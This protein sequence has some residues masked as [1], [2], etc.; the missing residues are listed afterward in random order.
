MAILLG[1]DTGGTYTDAVLFDDDISPGSTASGGV[2][3][4]AKALTTKH[5]LAE[6]IRNAIDAVLPAAPPDIRL[7]SL[8]TTLATNAIVEGHGTPV[9]LLL[10]GY[11]RDA[12][13]LAGLR[14]AVGNDPV[15]FIDGG[16]TVS[17]E[18]QMPLDVEA[19]RQAILAHAPK[20]TAFAVSGYFAVRN[21]E[22]ELAV[23]DMA[24]A[25]TGLPVSCGHE[26]TSALDAP[27]RALTTVINARLIPLLQQLILAVRGILEEKGVRASLMVVKGD[28]SLIDAEVALRQP[29]QTILS[30]P[31]ASVVGARFL[32]GEDDVLVVDMGGT[33]SDVA[34][35]QGGRPVLNR[36]GATVGGWRTMVEAVAVHTFGLGGDSEV[37]LNEAEQLVVGPRRVVP[38]SLL[39]QQRPHVLDVLRRQLA[40]QDA[41]RGVDAR[42]AVGQF[43]LRQRSLEAGRGT[44]TREQQLVWD[45]LGDGIVSLAELFAEPRAAYFRRL[46]LSQLVDRSLVVISAFT[47]TD[48]AHVLGYQSD[49]SAEA[50]SLGAALWARR[51]HGVWGESQGQEGPEDATA[52]S[53]RVMRQVVVQSGR[54]LVAA[55]LAEAHGVEL[56]DG[57]GTQHNAIRHLFVDRALDGLAHEDAVLDVTLALRRPIVAI[58]APVATYY[59][60]VAQRLHTRLCIPPYAGNANAVGAVAGGVMQTVRA[61]IKLLDAEQGY[62][63]HLPTGIHDFPDLQA[64][65]DFALCETGR[66]AEAQA[67]EA[68]AAD[69]QVQSQRHDHIA[70]I[71]KDEVYE[72]MYIDTEVVALA[73]GRPKLAERLAES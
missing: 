59:P 10:V 1:I 31:A 3:G 43:A 23:R 44:L 68:G 71:R 72:D 58:G 2:I 70:R 51:W 15:V 30:G 8:S 32:S 39:A 19:A 28:G 69:V 20:V 16:H 66:L 55:A 22:H 29:V 38:L 52:F 56:E 57:N 37:R 42:N 67:R 12:L 60:T 18:E 48:A 45:M 9:C 26:L 65:A 4:S 64:A 13:D 62:R 34:L 24:R 40:A 11:P 36:D 53:Q 46:A 25:L 47:P 33:T 14:Q 50:S 21:P 61:Q 49:W 5:D 17:G 35:L 41:E 73:F 27:R 7:V 6:G 63:V 54:A